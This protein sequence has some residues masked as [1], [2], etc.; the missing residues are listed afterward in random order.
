MKKYIS[1]LSFLF[2]LLGVSA[3]DPAPLLQKVRARLDQVNDY[4]ASGLMKTN[5]PFLK[6]PEA[7]VTI[8]FKRPDKI[9]I[10]N[11]KGISLVPK[12]AVTISLNTLLRGSYTTLDAGTDTLDGHKVRLIKLLPQDETADLVL[13]T[14]YI[15]ESRLLILKARTTTRENGTYEVELAYGKYISYALPD[16]VVFTFNTKDYKLPKGITFDYDDGSVKKPTATGG[17]GKVEINYSSYII[18]KGV[19]DTVFQ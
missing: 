7:Q 14:L 13:A 6:V 10:R 19:A 5:V 11:D 15:D 16:K 9:K 1:F 2:S 4:Q 8:Y 12:G 17:K 18:N 3:Q